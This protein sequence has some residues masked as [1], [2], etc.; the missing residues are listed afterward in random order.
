MS[1]IPREIKICWKTYLLSVNQAGVRVPCK[2]C[3]ATRRRTVP[4]QKEMHSSALKSASALQTGRGGERGEA[5]GMKGFA[6]LD[7]L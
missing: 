4:L 3:G 1:E 2:V 7:L 5:L 6:L